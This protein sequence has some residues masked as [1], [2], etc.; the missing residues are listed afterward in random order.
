MYQVLIQ[1]QPV[2]RT[3]EWVEAADYCLAHN[4]AIWL[5]K[6]IFVILPFAKIKSV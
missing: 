2:Y 3:S 1:G 4:L 5:H 6:T